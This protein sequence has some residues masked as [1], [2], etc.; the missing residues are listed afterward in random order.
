[1]PAS[2][3]RAIGLPKMLDIAMVLAGISKIV[4]G[5]FTSHFIVRLGSGVHIAIVGSSLR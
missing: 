2:D 4:W 1:M 3:L 5:R